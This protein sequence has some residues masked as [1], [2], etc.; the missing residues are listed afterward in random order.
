MK[1]KNELIT[2]QFPKANSYDK[3]LLC[4]VKSVVIPLAANCPHNTN[5]SLK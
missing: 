3:M 2:T 1:T 4:I 5:I